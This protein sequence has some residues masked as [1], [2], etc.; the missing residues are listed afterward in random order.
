M[1]HF[2]VPRQARD[3]AEQI[4]QWW[5]AR[6]VQQG[7]V[8]LIATQSFKAGW[9]ECYRALGSPQPDPRPTP[10][11][12]PPRIPDPEPPTTIF[13]PGVEAI[14]A[15]LKTPEG[16]AQLMLERERRKKRYA[17]GSDRI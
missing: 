6:K 1:S 7:E 5:N 15:W 16:R 14:E 9:N 17:S 4:G 13:V 8:Q 12:K 3:W 11:A 10:P 2:R